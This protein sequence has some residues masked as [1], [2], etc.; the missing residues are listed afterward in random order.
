MLLKRW[1]IRLVPWRIAQRENRHHEG[2]KKNEA[3]KTM[4]LIFLDQTIQEH[5]HT[6]DMNNQVFHTILRGLSRILAATWRLI[7]DKL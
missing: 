3:D 5:G 1:R 2:A 7:P 6:G 4:L